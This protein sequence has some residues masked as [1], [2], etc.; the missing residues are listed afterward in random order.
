MS[1]SPQVHFERSFFSG[2]NV[3][4][5]L[6]E[7]SIVDT[8]DMEVHCTACVREGHAFAARRRRRHILG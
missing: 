4:S 7:E 8:L 1:E 5:L 2:M 6:N 3:V